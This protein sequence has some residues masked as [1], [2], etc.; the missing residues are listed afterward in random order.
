MKII[1]IDSVLLKSMP[2]E[3]KNTLA[4][5]GAFIFGATGIILLQVL[6]D[7]RLH[8]AIAAAIWSILMIV[9]LGT[10]YWANEIDDREQ[11]GDNLYYLG[12]LFTLTALIWT[13]IH[14]FDI[15]GSN[16]NQMRFNERVGS[17][18]SNF[19]IA[20]IST[21]VGILARIVLHSFQY[22]SLGE[23]EDSNPGADM[24][25]DMAARRFRMELSTATDSFSHYNRLISARAEAVERKIEQAAYRSVRNI[26]QTGKDASIKIE[27]AFLQV[28]ES[29]GVAQNAFEQG[30][31]RI[32][33]SVKEMR[34]QTEILVKSFESATEGREHLM[35]Q[36]KQY[37]EDIGQATQ[38]C[39][40]NLGKINS[41]MN[42]TSK[43][44]QKTY[45]EMHEQ[46]GTLTKSLENAVGEIGRLM[47]QTE[48]FGENMKKTA[49]Q[50][51]KILE[52]IDERISDMIE[53]TDSKSRGHWWSFSKL[54]AVVEKTA[55]NRGNI[56]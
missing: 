7:S 14:S 49:L 5:F 46:T 55:W 45:L 17:L 39:A 30:A 28:A 26:E 54:V 42:D 10:Y 2:G 20:L 32:C 27:K 48:Q 52:E 1:D 9:L 36:T 38:Q 50:C 53:E 33:T 6:F 37:G 22:G 15:L 8:G 29:T 23:S 4:L 13:I 44:T 47:M 31:E 21:V 34:E 18:L 41:R 56:G 12:L 11:E 43:I 19:G 35:L 24:S 3:S 40:E 16:I 51:A 25:L